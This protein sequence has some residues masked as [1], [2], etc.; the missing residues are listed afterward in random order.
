MTTPDARRR[1]WDLIASGALTAV[2]L[3][4]AVPVAIARTEGGDPV[5]AYCT[6]G[7]PASVAVFDDHERREARRAL[8]GFD[9]VANVTFI[10]A[11]QIA[12]EHRERYPHEPPDHMLEDLAIGAGPEEYRFSVTDDD[13][14][15]LVALEYRVR[16][17]RM[18]AEAA[19][20][21]DG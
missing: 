17:V 5:P 20:C 11:E 14:H 16:G 15:V 3:A 9:E 21:P 10:D 1:P 4:I 12:D 8:E 18:G 6:E 7:T 2:L 13:P 19:H